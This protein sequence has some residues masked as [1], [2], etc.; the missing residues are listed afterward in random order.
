MN[1]AEMEDYIK[2]GL[3]KDSLFLGQLS[4]RFSGL[5]QQ[6]L[7]ILLREIGE[8][9][10]TDKVKHSS[11][12]ERTWLFIVDTTEGPFHF[13]AW[14]L[15]NGHFS[16]D[17]KVTYDEIMA[18]FN[19]HQEVRGMN[20]LDIVNKIIEL[21]KH[22]QEVAVLAAHF[23]ESALRQEF[24]EDTIRADVEMNL[25]TFEIALSEEQCEEIISSVTL[26]I[27]SNYD[28]SSYNEHI[29]NLINNEITALLNKKLEEVESV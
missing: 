24:Y 26:D 29:S 15:G 10:V 12:I 16:Y 18:R 14:D 20:Q 11:C 22:N 5:A 2:K 19:K 6:N 17:F 23:N 3:A 27:E 21:T 13:G 28:H 1:K 4:T 8:K 25:D 7:N 9:E